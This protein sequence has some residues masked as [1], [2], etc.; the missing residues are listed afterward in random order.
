MKSRLKGRVRYGLKTILSL[1]VLFILSMCNLNENK[2][3]KII[4]LH[5]ST[6]QAIW[7]GS[8]NRYIR[9][10]TDKSD[11]KTF[12]KHYNKN[13]DSQYKIIEQSFPKDSPYGWS[14]MPY[15]YYN[16][17]VKNAGQEAYK[18]EPTLEILTKEYDII[19]FKHCY[20]VSKIQEDTGI[21]DINSNEQ[22]LEN[23]KLQYNALKKKMHEFP[24]TKF[25]VWTPAAMVRNNLKE[26][27]ARRTFE[28]YKWMLEEWNEGGDNIFIW[29]F[30][31]YET[32][33][34][35]YLKDE[36]SVS[37]DDSHPNKDF[38]GR[39]APLFA[40]FIIEVAENRVN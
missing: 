28:F 25:I 16:I 15:D 19:I 12:F 38:A 29:D 39:I 26:E 30:Y 34:T 2:M 35:L 23:Y 7:Y 33:G 13:N 40:K 3:K 9:K 8:V 21:P 11:V 31:N 24:N 20:P 1:L 37:P 18:E 27:E 10:L 17:W 4:F 6:G 36:N 22:R 14:N 32:E 5:H